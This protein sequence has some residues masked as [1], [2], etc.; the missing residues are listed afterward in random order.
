MRETFFLAFFQEENV[1]FHYTVLQVTV[2][3]FSKLGTF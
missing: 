1:F 3:I 2:K